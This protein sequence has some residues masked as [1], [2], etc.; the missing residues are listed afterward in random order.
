[1]SEVIF[2]Y[3]VILSPAAD[4][5]RISAVRLIVDSAADDEPHGH[6]AEF[7][8]SELRRI[9][10]SLRMTGEGLGMTGS[11]YTPAG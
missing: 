2:I 4:G 7:T 9:F 11:R 5:R 1:M 10:A 8:L 6:F 3:G